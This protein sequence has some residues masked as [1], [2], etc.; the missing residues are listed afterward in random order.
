[1]HQKNSHAHVLTNQNP[2]LS[3]NNVLNPKKLLLHFRALHHPRPITARTCSKPH[4]DGSHLPAIDRWAKLY[5]Y[6]TLR[7]G[8]VVVWVETL[9][10]CQ[11]LVFA[12]RLQN[13]CTCPDTSGARKIQ[14]TASTDQQQNMV[15][16]L[17]QLAS[18][19]RLCIKSVISVHTGIS[20]PEK[21]SAIW[22][23]PSLLRRINLRTNTTNSSMPE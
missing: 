15:G 2:S 18:Q 5:R 1:M 17:L 9:P 22:S 10:L 20:A 4:P 6:I 23:F 11:R 8:P 3:Q 16:C 19:Q 12:T 13:S 21:R 14:K 7:T